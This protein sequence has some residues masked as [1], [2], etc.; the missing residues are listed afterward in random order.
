MDVH[1]ED[2]KANQHTVEV[3][4]DD[5]AEDLR[6]K[7]ASAMG[8]PEDSFCMSFGDEAMG[9]GADMTQLSAG[10]TI[11]L[12]NTQKYEAIAALHALG[13]RNITPERLEDVEDPEVAC[14]L[15]QAEVATVIP[16]EFLRKAWVTRLDLSA[17]SIVTQIGDNFL[18]GTSLTTIDLSG[19]SNVTVIGSHFLFACSSLTTLDLTPLNHVTAIGSGFLSHC[20]S[21]T[22]LALPLNVTRIES[23]FLSGCNSLTTVDLTPLNHVTVIGSRFLNECSSLTTLDLSPLNNVTM[24]GDYFLHACNSLTTLDLS[25]LKNVT[26]IGRYFLDDCKSL[27]TLDLSPLNKVQ[28]VQTCMIS[29]SGFATSCTSLKSIYLSGCSSA[30]S[31]TVRNSEE[32]KHL[33]VEARP[34]R[35]RDESPE[36]AHKRQRH[37]Q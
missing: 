4:A 28:Y 13:E 33:V 37:A 22:T 18:E 11:N 23:F 9:E 34:K 5:T 25:P 20:N 21:L 26:Q 2:F 17:V 10:D 6:R 35:S 15:L 36:Q 24:I 16:D 3:G 1:F 8:L 29:G 7:V 30:V 14:L 19:L 12:T 32:L 31:S 27:A